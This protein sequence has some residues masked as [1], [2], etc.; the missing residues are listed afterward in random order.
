MALVEYSS[1]EKTV[2]VVTMNSGEN[3][4][5][6][7]FIK[8]YLDVLDQVERETT[9]STLVVSSSHEKIFSNGLDLEWLRPVFQNREINVISD[10][11]YL[12]NRL[13]KRILLYPMITVAA[14]NGHAFAAGAIL[15]CAFDF[16]FMR[17][18]R[19]Y[20]CLPEID[21]GMPFLPGMLALLKKAIPMYLLEEL[22][23]TGKRLTA[24]ECEK[25][26]IITRA[27]PVETLMDEAM[28][29]AKSLNKQRGIIREMK[30]RMYHE[31][32][33]ALDNQDG[34]YIESAKYVY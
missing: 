11:F 16:R 27:C 2:A 26:H 18:D 34:S 7:A 15:T 24:A 28:A 14:V 12:M 25:H 19:G 31:I 32:V 20:F 3:R 13:Y 6:P 10:F 9:A 17:S 5:N 33:Q 29:F 21:L 4:L 30:S 23:Y 1:D 22:Q 8:T